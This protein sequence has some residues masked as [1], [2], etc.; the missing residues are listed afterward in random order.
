MVLNLKLL[1]STSLLVSQLKAVSTILFSRCV[2][3]PG[4]KCTYGYVCVALRWIIGQRFYVWEKKVARINDFL[5]INSG[6]SK[7]DF[8]QVAV[9]F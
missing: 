4:S 7:C 6:H 3:D 8:E 2:Q 9:K 1:I 5:E